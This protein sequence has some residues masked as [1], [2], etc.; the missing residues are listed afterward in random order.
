MP[1]VSKLGSAKTL[2]GQ[3]REVI[4]NV[5]T[6]MHS[7][8]VRGTPHNLKQVQ[9]RVALATGISERS[10]RNVIKQAKNIE[11]GDASSFSTPGK[12]R[13]KSNSKCKLDDFDKCVVRRTI[14]NFHT[15]YKEIPTMEKVHRK[16]VE[17]IHFKGSVSSLRGIVRKLHFRWKKTE[18]NRKILME[19]HD[20]RLLRMR[21]LR[22]VK[23]YRNEGRPIIYT[24]ETYVHSSHTKPCSW[25][26][27]TKE[28]LKKTSLKRST[29]D[30]G[31]CW[32]QSRFHPR[33]A[34]GV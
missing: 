22:S 16:L 9:K 21:F 30:S 2:H 26:D 14:H 29:T 17:D 3:T 32:L 25:T 6:F 11:V 19:R 28:G 34:I 31:T 4:Y 13:P 24:D 8:M 7:E 18:D 20:I 15:I 23:N 27:G 5:Y 33:C 12:K 1:P 10:V